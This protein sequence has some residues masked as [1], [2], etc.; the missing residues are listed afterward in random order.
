MSDLPQ[1]PEGTT[2]GSPGN[3]TPPPPIDKDSIRSQSES[4]PPLPPKER[5]RRSSNLQIVTSNPE[6]L[7]PVSGVTKRR[8]RRNNQFLNQLNAFKHW[9]FESTKRGK[10]PNKIDSIDDQTNG[11]LHLTSK[12]STL[13]PNYLHHRDISGTSRSS[14][15]TSLTPVTSNNQPRIDTAR[16]RPH[17]NSL[18]PSPL[19]PRSSYR[20]SSTGLRGRKSTSSSVSSIR[21]IPRHATHSKASS[22]SSNSL[23]TINSPGNRSVGRSPHSSVKVL[24]ITPTGS[25]LPSNI[26]VVRNHDGGSNPNEVAISQMN[27]QSNGTGVLFARRKKSPFKGP[28]L[29][30]NFFGVNIGP[31]QGSPAIRM[32]ESSDGK[33]NLGLRDL[34]RRTGDKSRRKSQI[35]EEEEEEEAEDGDIEEVDQFPPVEVGRGESVHSITIWDDSQMTSTL[36][37]VNSN[38]DEGKE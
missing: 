30:S 24:P 19:T 25:H 26:R 18:S 14:F 23:D 3:S 29:N 34:T 4:R 6:L 33:I 20:R 32:R 11:A 12:I 28:M 38:K 37:E 8:K 1:L 10:S 35:I 13:A 27:P 17:R 7:G 31:S 36:T 16:I 2:I 9:F 5:R 15:G 22:R 21:S